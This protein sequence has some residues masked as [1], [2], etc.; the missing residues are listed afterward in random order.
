[1]ARPSTT[2]TRT[3]G[4]AGSLAVEGEVDHRELRTA[5]ALEGR[6]RPEVAAGSQGEQ[7]GVERRR[8]RAWDIMVT[9]VTAAHGRVARL[10]LVADRCDRTPRPRER[11]A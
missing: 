2:D 3:V 11:D 9:E 4:A 6:E 7:G 1:M 10:A 8:S 5:V